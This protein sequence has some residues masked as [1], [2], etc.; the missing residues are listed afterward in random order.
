MRTFATATAPHL[1]GGTS[2]RRMMG[3]TLLALL[4]GLLAQTWFFGAGVPLQFA[5][6]AGF[7]L[8]IEAAAQRLRGEAPGAA[9]GDLSALVCAAIFAACVAPLSPWWVAALGML[10]GIGLAKQAYGGLGRNLFNPAMA[11]LTVALLLA[12]QA[13]TAWP[14]LPLG[15]GEALQAVL[16]GTPPGWDSWA[17]ATPLD[18]LRQLSAQ[19]YAAP[20]LPAQPLFESARADAWRWIAA[21]H[22]LGGVYLLARG[23]IGWQVPAGVIGGCLLLTLPFW[24]YDAEQH[25]APWLHLGQGGLL[26]AAWIVA[27]DPVTG[28]TSPRGRLLFGLGVAAATLALRRW[29]GQ[30]DGVAFAVLALNALAPLLDRLTRPRIRGHLRDG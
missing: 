28:C 20:Q 9:L 2:V 14:A 25:P 18:A 21:A 1:T 11:G 24:L 3:D 19:G 17:S 6:A 22:T 23:V 7:A 30:P 26:L 12:P 8:L 15:V 16:S 27:N 10:V 29:G 13:M 5:L 4:P